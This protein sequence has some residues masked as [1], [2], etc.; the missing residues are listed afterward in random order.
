[1]P[2][3]EI[4]SLRYDWSFIST[5]DDEWIDSIKSNR[6]LRDAE[7]LDIPI[8]QYRAK[9]AWEETQAPGIRVL[10]TEARHELRQEI[11]K[12]ELRRTELRR[13]WFKV[14]GP[15]IVALTGLIGAL[16]GLVALLQK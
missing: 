16:I 7:K 9:E 1:M 15:V 14:V 2:P 5:L 13:E 11:R 3:N 4:E 8:P 12:E 10:T 6:L